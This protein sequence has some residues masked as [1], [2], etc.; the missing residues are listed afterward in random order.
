MHVQV[1]FAHQDVTMHKMSCR[2]KI[3][4]TLRKLFA[5]FAG[6]QE[7]ETKRIILGFLQMTKTTYTFSISLKATATLQIKDIFPVYNYIHST[8]L[9]RSSRPLITDQTHH[10]PN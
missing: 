1:K 9:Y 5:R 8:H 4:K 2:F 3:N 6:A 10:T 7:R